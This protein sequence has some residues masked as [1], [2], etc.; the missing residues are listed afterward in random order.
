VSIGIADDSYEKIGIGFKMME[1]RL[2]RIKHDNFF[3]DTAE[4]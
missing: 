2:F 1:I 4:G 3:A